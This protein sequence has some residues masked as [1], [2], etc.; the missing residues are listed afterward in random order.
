MDDA[1]ERVDLEAAQR[2]LDLERRERELLIREDALARR[3]SEL[4]QA[5][6]AAAALAA[7]RRRQIQDADLAT[8]AKCDEQAAA[9]ASIQEIVS[10]LQLREGYLSTALEEAK[11]A[12]AALRQEL[13]QE[14]QAAATAREELSIARVRSGRAL[15]EE[16]A[17][18]KAKL[19]QAEAGIRSLSAEIQT[20]RDQDRRKTTAMEELSRANA[21]ASEQL[22]RNLET[23]Q[24]VQHELD[25][26]RRQLRKEGPCS[27][28]S[29]RRYLRP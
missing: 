22:R 1:A 10:R 4:T 24:R 23:L 19:D 11:E 5:E 21:N 29:A 3:S 17:K 25:E 26:A 13:T 16:Q 20:L 14:R 18:W 7:D 28:N 12:H 2:E 9:L 8:K 6:A 27:G 15:A